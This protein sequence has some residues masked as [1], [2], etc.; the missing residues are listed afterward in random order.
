MSTRSSTTEPDALPDVVLVGRVRR[1]HGVRGQILVESLSDVA[2]RF[3]VGAPL[4]LVE[5]GGARREVE[6][7]FAAPHGDGVR[8]G[9][10]GFDD[11]DA[12]ETWRGAELYCRRGERPAAPEGGFYYYELVGCRCRDVA[13]GDLGEVV[14]V[15]EDGGG[16]QLRLEGGSR[17]LLVPFVRSMLR[18]VDVEG[19]SIELQLPEG[20]VEAC[21]YPS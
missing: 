13:V 20:F 19:R 1:P 7:A 21:A 3:A 2:E 11:R 15:L 9:L 6:V 18:R 12:V 8:L 16:H 10:T 14:E 5:E 4:I 17:G